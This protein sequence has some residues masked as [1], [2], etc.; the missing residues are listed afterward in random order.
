MVKP[1]ADWPGK[2]HKIC[3]YPDPAKTD[4]QGAKIDRYAIICP[5][6]A[7]P[8]PLQSDISCGALGSDA[9]AAEA[10]NSYM[11]P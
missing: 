11:R 10:N 7:L 5:S 3:S 2:S 6:F 9:E 8:T 4:S 1:Q